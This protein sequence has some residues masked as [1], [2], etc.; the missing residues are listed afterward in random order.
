MGDGSLYVGWL[1]VLALICVVEYLVA[2]VEHHKLEMHTFLQM[3]C[4]VTQVKHPHASVVI[5]KK[6]KKSFD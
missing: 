6:N 4:P 3:G 5:L 2:C 1:F